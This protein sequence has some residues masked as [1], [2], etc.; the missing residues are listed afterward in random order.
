MRGVSRLSVMR[1]SASAAVKPAVPSTIA[2]RGVSPAGW[3]I[4]AL[5]ASRTYWL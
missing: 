5:A 3:A 1:S 4:T 2:S